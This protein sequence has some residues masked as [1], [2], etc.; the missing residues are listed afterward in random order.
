MPNRPAGDPYTVGDDSP[1][2]IQRQVNVEG[3]LIVYKRSP[4]HRTIMD[5]AGDDAVPEGGVG[6]EELKVIVGIDPPELPPIIVNENLIARVVVDPQE[7]LDPSRVLARLRGALRVIV[8][9][10][11][12]FGEFAEVL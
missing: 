8:A 10:L 11:R 9:L 1:R 4:A 6:D 5:R 12:G 3:I 7:P 2:S